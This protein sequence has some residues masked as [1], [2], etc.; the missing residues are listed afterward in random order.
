[1]NAP[2]G[3]MFGVIILL[4]TLLVV[5]T[6]RWT[7]IDSKALQ[8]NSLNART[9]IDEEKIDRGRILAD[10]NEVLAKSVPARGGTFTRTYPTGSLFAQAV[11]YS[12]VSEGEGAGLELSAGSYLRGVQTGLSSVFGQLG[13]ST[14]VGDDVYTSLDPTAQQEAVSQLDGRVGSVVALDPQTGAVKVMYSNPTYNDNDPSASGTNIS[15]FNNATQGGYAPG[16]T[17]KVVTTAAALDSG[18]FTP[19]SIINGNSPITVSGVPL[20]NDGNQSW[21]PVTLTKALTYSINTVYAQ[22][23]QDVGRATMQTYMKRFGFYSTPPLDYPPNEMI[24]SGVRTHAGGALLYPTNTGV[25]LGRMSIGQE[26]LLVTPLQ[27][28]MVAATIA[29]HGKLMVPHMISKVVNQ[30]GAVVD[31]IK[32]TVYGQVMSAANA[33][34]ETQMMTDVVE[35]GTGTSANLEG[36]KVAGKT[37]TATVGESG[38]VPLD[39]AWFIGFA[40]VNNPKVAV[41]VLLPSIPNGYGG[42]FAA[43]IAANIIKTLLAE[44]Q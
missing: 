17:F 29:N 4:F 30:D 10:N 28:A 42:Q 22:V 21:G 18:K 32:P 33:N 2:I 38:G 41:A 37:G 40:P 13:G 26:R 31:T 44:G 24:A 8:N 34:A 19:N 27:M 3:R 36:V 14:Q 43:P 5:W 16:S 20:E 11:G 15:R 39:N 1:M 7:V 25:D 12:I 9:L 23:G 35:E 6:T